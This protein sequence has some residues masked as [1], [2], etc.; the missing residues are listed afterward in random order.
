MK[1]VTQH[2]SRNSKKSARLSEPDAFPFEDPE[3][4]TRAPCIATLDGLDSV[5]AHSGTWHFDYALLGNDP[6]R[7]STQT[8]I[9][10]RLGH[11]TSCSVAGSPEAI[12]FTP[13]SKKNPLSC[14]RL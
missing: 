12:A 9:P 7:Q 8:K 3:L 13:Q 2:N 5:V 6:W 10:G 4:N 1:S 14:I 11:V